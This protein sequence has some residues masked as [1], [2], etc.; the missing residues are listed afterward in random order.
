M[1]KDIAFLAIGQAGGNIGRLFEA[2]KFKV[3][4]INTSSEDLKTL[5][6]AKYTYHIKNGEGAAKDRGTAKKLVIDDIKDLVTEITKTI[7]EEYIYVI[8]SAGGGTGSGASPMLI[9]YLSEIMPQRKI[10]GI[11]ILPSAGESVKAQINAYDCFSELDGLT[12]MHGLFVI[13]NNSRTDRL[14]LN[15]TF[16]DLFV[17]MLKMPGYTDFRGNIDTR[18]LK[19]VLGAPGCIVIAALPGGQCST[20]ELADSLKNSIFAQAEQD[21]IIQ[22]IALSAASE[23]NSAA[24]YCRTAH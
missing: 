9:T 17:L 4:Y 18:E 12:K 24:L 22:Y 15:E 1:K 8:F 14:T 5:P 13:D 11:T 23:I 16:V 19:E 10:G 21:G 2:L 6:E 3:M 20:S 7:A